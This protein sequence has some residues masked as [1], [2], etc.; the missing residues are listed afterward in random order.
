MPEVAE[1]AVHGDQAQV[2]AGIVRGGDGV[3]DDVEPVT[4]GGHL[5]RVRGDDESVGA[6]PARVVGLVG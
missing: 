5:F 6:E 1:R 2:R 3:D 4:G